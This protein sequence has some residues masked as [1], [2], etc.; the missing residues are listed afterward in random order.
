[1]TPV[2]RY[3]ANFPH[4]WGLTDMHGNVWEWCEDWCDYNF[5]NLFPEADPV[6]RGKHFL[7]VV[8]GTADAAC[9]RTRGSRQ[10]YW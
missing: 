7:P 4:P 5:Y 9:W 6:C 1:M 3:A 10:Y 2:G 8:G